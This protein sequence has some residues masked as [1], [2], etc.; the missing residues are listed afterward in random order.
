MG[1]LVNHEGSSVRCLVS[2]E[3][4]QCGMFSEP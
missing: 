4:R 3:G 1:C 2:H